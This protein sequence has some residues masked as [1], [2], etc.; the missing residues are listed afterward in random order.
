M[1][2]ILPPFFFPHVCVSQE[3]CVRFEQILETPVST[4]LLHR[5][6]RYLIGHGASRIPMYGSKMSG[7]RNESGKDIRIV[8]MATL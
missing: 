7:S 8:M 2:K 3:V 5:W 4:S 1:G 6:V